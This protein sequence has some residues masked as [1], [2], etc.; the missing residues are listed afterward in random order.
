L[1]FCTSH[2]S[3]LLCSL[4]HRALLFG[5]LRRPLPSMPTSAVAIA[6]MH[7][8]LALMESCCR[9][10]LSQ[11]PSTPTA[12]LSTSSSPSRTASRCPPVVPSHRRGPHGPTVPLRGPCRYRGPPIC[13]TVGV[14]LLQNLLSS[15]ASSGE[16]PLSNS[17]KLGPVAPA[18]SPATS[19]PAPCRWLA[20]F[21]GA[22]TGATGGS[23]SPVFWP[24]D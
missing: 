2:S 20:G 6:H 12:S 24:W 8:A 11:R 3:S 15:T 23:R 14:P 22:N 17:P 10:T 4:S 9:P 5:A 7:E 21:G 16:F 19:P 18:C 13:A 1:A